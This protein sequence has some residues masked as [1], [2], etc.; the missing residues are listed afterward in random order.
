[1]VREM[2]DKHDYTEIPHT[3]KVNWYIKSNSHIFDVPNKIAA[4]HNVL[5]ST[6]AYE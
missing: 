1:M 2:R 4:A 5:I 6:F 3:Q